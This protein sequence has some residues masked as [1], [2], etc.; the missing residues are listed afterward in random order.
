MDLNS[1]RIEI[2]KIDRKIVEYLEKRFNLSVEIGRYKK[3]NNLPVYDGDRE[4][5]VIESCVG[6]LQNQ[7]YAKQ[8]E[9][10][11]MQIMNSSKELQI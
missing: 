3:E 7:D 4:K 6:Y 8:I 5:K 9:D 10:V 11:Y 1:A 2:N